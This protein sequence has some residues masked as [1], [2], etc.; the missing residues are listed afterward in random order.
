MLQWSLLMSMSYIFFWKKLN[1]YSN[2]VRTCPDGRRP[3]RPITCTRS[4]SLEDIIC[5]HRVHSDKSK[6]PHIPKAKKPGPKV[7][8]G[9]LGLTSDTTAVAAQEPNTFFTPKLKTGKHKKAVDAVERK[10][11]GKV[12]RVCW[13]MFTLSHPIRVSTKAFT[14]RLANI[15]AT[16]RLLRAFFQRCIGRGGADIKLNS[17]IGKI[18]QTQHNLRYDI[19]IWDL[20]QKD[21]WHIHEKSINHTH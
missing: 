15:G 13:K 10:W 14:R 17:S 21:S 8:R 4:W 1:K 2:V 3:S 9:R 16:N 18:E 6:R 19:A 12:I 20:S 7:A 5:G 11:D